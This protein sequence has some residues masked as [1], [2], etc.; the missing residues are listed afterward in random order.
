M[1]LLLCKQIVQEMEIIIYR[2]DVYKS[3]TLEWKEKW[4]PAV[5]MYAWKLKKDIHGIL[6][7]CDETNSTS[8]NMIRKILVC[9]IMPCFMYMYHIGLWGM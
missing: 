3:F 5:I 2:P 4:V 7:K 1:L 8:S 9:I 6:E